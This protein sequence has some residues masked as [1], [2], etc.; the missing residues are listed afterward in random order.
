MDL[1]LNQVF[2]SQLQRNYFRVI[3]VTIMSVEETI[4]GKRY[5]VP[6]P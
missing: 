2:Q 5:T 3:G 4:F 1:F 6:D